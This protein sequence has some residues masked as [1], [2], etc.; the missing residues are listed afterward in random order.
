MT[1]PFLE[2]ERTF[3]PGNWERYSNRQHTRLI[4][5][6]LIGSVTY[7][8]DLGQYQPLLEVASR[9]HIGKQTTF[10]M[11]KMSFACLT[12]QIAGCRELTKGGIHSSIRD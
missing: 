8:G 12:Q 3:H 5:G 10:G 7:E 4:M 6:G 1:E 9:V 2:G 11:G